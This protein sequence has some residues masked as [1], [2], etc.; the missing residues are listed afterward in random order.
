M[1]LDLTKPKAP[2]AKTTQSKSKSNTGKPG[3]AQS[4]DQLY[5][6]RMKICIETA[7]AMTGVMAVF[8]LHAD[9]GLLMMQGAVISDAVVT[10]AKEHE[11]VADGI[12]ILGKGSIWTKL[13]G[14]GLIV[15]AQLCVNHGIIKNPE[16]LAGAGVVTPETLINLSK[17]RLMEI[18]LEAIKQQQEAQKRLEAARAEAQRI[19]EGSVI[20]G[21]TVGV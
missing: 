3:V 14:A 6:H 4:E 7:D 5:Q 9:A 13:I 2:P 18:E 11:K 17:T 21:E 12:E 10:V 19:A 20:N 15:G 16:K 8:G 1:A